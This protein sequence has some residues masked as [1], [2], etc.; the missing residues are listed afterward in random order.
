MKLQ[1][2]EPA[3]QDLIRGFH[4][5]ESQ[6]FQFKKFEIATSIGSSKRFPYA[7]YYTID[8]NSVLVQCGS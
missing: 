4:F 2:L 1:I 7:I 3:E 5:Y 8:N 6:F